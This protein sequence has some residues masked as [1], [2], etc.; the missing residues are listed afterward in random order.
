[1]A[2][3][4]K[5]PF[6]WGEHDVVLHAYAVPSWRGAPIEVV[7]MD[8]DK[9]IRIEY[10][11]PQDLSHDM[12]I[13]YSLSSAAHVAMTDAVVDEVATWKR[14]KKKGRHG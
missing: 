6:P 5:T 14:Q 1:M 12:V 9:R 7:V 13:L 2:S 11:Q 8:G 10:L 4:K 3:R